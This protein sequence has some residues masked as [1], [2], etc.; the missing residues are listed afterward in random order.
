MPETECLQEDKVEVTTGM[1]QKTV[2]VAMKQERHRKL[3]WHESKRAME[4]HRTVLTQIK[5][6]E[7]VLL[8]FPPAHL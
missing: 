8:V 4:R 2:E 3:Q 5:I 1:S 6:K 7:G